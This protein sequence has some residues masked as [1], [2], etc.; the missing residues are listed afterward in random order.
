MARRKDNPRCVIMPTV[1]AT[2]HECLRPID[3]PTHVN[4]EEIP[5]GKWASCE[6][7]CVVHGRMS[8][9][10]QREVETLVGEQLA[11]CG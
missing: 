5:N 10:A 1:F 2:C 4:P 9:L 6:E 7:H 8:P 3:G 11:L